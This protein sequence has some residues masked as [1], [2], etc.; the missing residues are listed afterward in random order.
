MRANSATLTFPTRADAQAFCKAY[1]RQTLRGHDMTAGTENVSVNVYN[2]TEG[3]R[4]WIDS[5]VEAIN[6]N[7]K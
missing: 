1:T 4:Q 6:E 5:Y 7:K 3:D 2:L